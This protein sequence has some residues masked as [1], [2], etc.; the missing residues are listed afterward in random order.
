MGGLLYPL[1]NSESEHVKKELADTDLF[2]GYERP[3]GLTRGARPEALQ[4]VEKYIHL[5]STSLSD[6][7]IGCDRRLYVLVSSLYLCV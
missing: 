5:D 1:S 6:R 2:V 7:R 4:K 3:I